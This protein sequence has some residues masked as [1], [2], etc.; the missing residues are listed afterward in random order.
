MNP[1]IKNC[2][3]CQAEIPS[4]SVKCPKC[5]KIEWT[6]KNIAITAVF[7]VI[8]AWILI[9]ILPDTPSNTASNDQTL[10]AQESVKENL[11]LGLSAVNTFT[12]YAT[13]T[14][15]IDD[16]NAEVTLFGYWA[17]YIEAGKASSSTEEIAMAKELEK[18][19]IAIQTKE[20]PKLRKE[21]TRFFRNTLWEGD[22]DVSVGGSKNETLSLVG[23]YFAANTN[24]KNA[25]ESMNPLLVKYRFQKI[26]FAW[27]R[28]GDWTYFDLK[29]DQRFLA[30]GQ[31]A[32]R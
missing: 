29:N 28:G 12:S 10:I 21:A 1:S 13:P 4:A 11:S 24:I 6:K 15:T 19:T 20:F 25:Y 8:F 9:S 32:S 26:Q 2:K 5:K 16:L 27:Y 17:K 23:A 30:D 3:F 18:K 7:A 22:I 14:S 31:L